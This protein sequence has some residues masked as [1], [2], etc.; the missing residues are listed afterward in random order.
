MGVA[1]AVF[2][3]SRSGAIVSSTSCERTP[4]FTSL[5]PLQVDDLQMSSR[6]TFGTIKRVG[7]ILIAIAVVLAAGVLIGQA[8]ALFGV[9]DDPEASITF[10]DQDGDGESVV[11]EEVTLSD[12]GFVV[13]TDGDDPRAVSEYLDSG[14]H[15]NVT[16]ERN[17]DEELAGR[18]TAT[19]HRDTTGDGS[20]AYEETDGAEDRPYL[21][22]GFPVADTATVT[23]TGIDDPLADS[24][25]V[26]SIDV[27]AVATT[28]DTITV[29]AEISNPTDLETQQP[30]DVRLDGVV[31][32]RQALTLEAG[33]TRDLTFEIDTT[34]M[35]PGERTVGVFTDGDGILETITLEFHT[36][37]AVEITDASEDGVT[38]DV[39]I[40]VDGFVAI[41]DDD[42]DIVGAS[43]ALEPGEHENVTVAFDENA[44]VD[45]DEEL[46][47][48]LYEGDP[49]DL[50]A[51]TP[52]ED[53][54][55]DGERV[56]TTF[57]LADVAN[58]D[59]GN[60]EDGSENDD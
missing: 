53:G 7:A 19:V 60:G 49:D 4:R 10:T 21:E 32:E 23:T 17:D 27:P 42:G 31:L 29:S 47:A 40:P 13:V 30:V 25:G 9:E 39:A 20:Y 5:E 33:E 18:L 8:P 16:V 43:D 35:A 36:E 3:P 24:F 12:G 57:T 22:D 55:D 37:P 6:V 45:D 11:V 51:A 54:D 48:V 1:D 28:N 58:G 56:E 59:D 2:S 15:E 44:T 46:T 41:E 38:A 26:D 52:F 14:T 34:R 50:E